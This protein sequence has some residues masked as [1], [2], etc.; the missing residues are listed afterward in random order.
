MLSGKQVHSA[1]PD[2]A[3]RPVSELALPERQLLVVDLGDFVVGDAGEGLVSK[4]S[5][6]R[7]SSR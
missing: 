3:D 6:P 5:E 7:Y 4:R 2:E 1:T